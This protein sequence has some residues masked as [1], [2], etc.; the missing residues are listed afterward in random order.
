MSQY[1]GWGGIP[2]IFDDRPEWQELQ[3]ELK[4]ITDSKEYAACRFSTINAHYTDESVSR[5]MW[6]LL[7]SLGFDGGSVL[8]PGCGRGVFIANMPAAI[9]ANTKVTGI[10]LDPVTASIA[11]ALHP[12]HDI[13]TEGFEDTG[14]K[15]STFSATIGNVPFGDIKLN[16]TEYNKDRQHSIH[17]HFILKSL[18]L[19]APGGLVCLLT[20]RFTLDSQD[21]AARRAMADIADLVAA[22]RLPEGAFKVSAN[23]EVVTDCLLFRR[24]AADEPARST[25]WVDSIRNQV[26]DGEAWY[27][28]YYGELHPEHVLG[29]HALARGMH[30]DAELTVLA[31]KSA[32]L[33][34]RMATTFAAI[35]ERA[36]ADG[37]V[38][39]ASATLAPPEASVP[40]GVKRGAF[41]VIDGRL[42][43]HDYDGTLSADHGVRDSEVDRVMRLVG[44]RDTAREIL[45]LQRGQWSGEGTAPWADA[46]RR[47]GEQYDG[48]LERYGPINTVKI[49]QLPP[50]EDGEERVQ[51]RYPNMRAFRPDPDSVFTSAIEIYDENSMTARRAPI[52]DSRVL[53]PRKLVRESSSIA[54]ALLV[55]LDE[56]GRIDL[57]RIG[58]LVGRTPDEA[59]AEL[60]A[61]KLIYR[62]PRAKGETEIRYET[63]D[64]YLSGDVRKKLARAEAAARKN[65]DT[66]QAAVDALRAVQPA[67]I[68]PERN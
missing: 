35:A 49:S 45:T 42:F 47:L 59:A 54:D 30:H 64:E 55:C 9:A 53:S 58:E 66:W 52:F 63:A 56:R 60:L 12:E 6:G 16:D 51:R 67:D 44:L 19:T 11:R 18:A 61:A 37:L 15:A 7:R 31:D 27:N 65:P 40:G 36:K 38:F 62:I 32:P 20:S 34:D 68:P 43:V 46:Q 28:R 10:E 3:D 23:T 57:A 1:R 8:E 50:G 13:R 21:R 17:N 29:T 24:R 26:G 33:A 5:K 25:A 39:S 22:V 4:A 14:I 2:Q 48:F 41:T